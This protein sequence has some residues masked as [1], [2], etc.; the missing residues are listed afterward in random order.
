MAA[1]AKQRKNGKPQVNTLPF[2]VL[3]VV[4]FA[5]Y[6]IYQHGLV[7]SYIIGIALFLTLIAVICIE[8]LNGVREYGYKRNIIEVIVVI[9][10]VVGVWYSMQFLLATHY[11]LD[12]V[13]SCSMLPTLQR[14]TMLLLHGVNSPSEIK[15]PIININQSTYASVVNE[16]KSGSLSCVAYMQNGNTAQV[17]QYMKPGYTVG[18]YSNAG[19]G[20]IVNVDGQNGPLKYQCGVTNVNFT[21]GTT[22]KIVY[23]SGI[24]IGTSSVSGDRNNSIVVYSTIPQDLF[25]QEGDGYIVHR[26]Y[27][28]LNVTGNYYV[29]TKGDNNP[30][31]DMQYSNYPVNMSYVQG[32]VIA[33]IPY[34]GYLKLILSS[35]FSEPAGC[36]S[37]IQN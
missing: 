15:A 33:S 31:L 29:L 28:I 7:L 22:A 19:G 26:A 37:T 32:K 1:K 23:T 18:L 30:G 6:L 13:P 27:A 10:V 21:N 36:N 16:A 25:Y 9:L 12:V 20:T 2:Y 5:L 4:L 8:T 11:P 34:L 24:S 17:S 3:L 14:G 35:H